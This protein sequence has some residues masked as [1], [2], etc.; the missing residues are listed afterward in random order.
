MTAYDGDALVRLGDELIA[1]MD[2]KDSAMLLY[3]EIEDGT[4]AG[5]VFLEDTNNLRRLPI[6][7]A[8]WRKFSDDWYDLPKEQ[9][10]SVM[11]Y[12]IKDKKFRAS[13][14]FPGEVNLTSDFE[15]QKRREE[16]VAREFFGDKPIRYPPPP[17]HAFD[18]ND[19]P[20]G[21]DGPLG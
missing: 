1:S 13:F 15:A 16:S 8:L 6:S 18:L 21:F 9:R 10:W 4:S 5:C 14:L 3:M 19:Y 17:A 12:F 20:P 11:R 7:R 2:R